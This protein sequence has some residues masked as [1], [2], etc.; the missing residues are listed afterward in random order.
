MAQYL[1]PGASRAFLAAAK[2]VTITTL[3]GMSRF[4]REALHE[5]EIDMAITVSMPEAGVVS[6]PIVDDD[7]VV[8]AG[9]NHTIFRGRATVQDL[10]RYRWVL[11]IRLLRQ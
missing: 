8:V 9:T 11:P 2:D 7:V 4:L 10:A 5:G 1:L 6:H 3:I